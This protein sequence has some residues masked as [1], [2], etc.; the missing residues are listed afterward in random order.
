MAHTVLSRRTMLGLLTTAASCPRVF[1]APLATSRADFLE[2]LSRRAFLYFWERASTATG[3]VLDRAVNSDNAD[4]RNVASCAATGFGLTALCIAAKRG[5]MDRE[6][7]RQRALTTLDHFAN[8]AAHEQGWFYHFVNAHTGERVWNSEISSIDTALLLGGVLTARQFFNDAEITRLAD[9]IYG[10]VDFRWM[11][12]GH[13]TLL[14][15]GWKPESGFLGCRW[16]SYSEH[17]I[18]HLLALGSPS[19]TIPAEAWYAWRRP[20]ISYAGINY[21]GGPTLF[22]HQYSHAWVDFRH[23][24][25]AEGA[26][27]DWFANSVNATL[28]HRA[29]CIDLGMTEFPGC[30][31]ANQWG[32]TSSDS[33]KGYVAW[34]GPPRHPAID[35]SIVPCA[36][37]GSLMFT[38]ELCLDALTTMKQ[39][40][41]DRIWNRYGFCDAFHPL[42]GWTAPDV[43]GIDLGITLLSAE[44]AR[45]GSVWQWFMQNEPIRRALSIAN[46]VDKTGKFA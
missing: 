28:A 31:D 16:D 36:A 23:L 29:F 19:L 22:V 41:G 46:I 2:D 42:N 24:H 40:F 34:G 6:R 39:R 25:E 37:A 14:C 33:A 7:L 38:P 3:L 32:I 4:S 43:L 13:P 30:Y 9:K 11:L 21:L 45:S 27:I 5:W 12:D 10:R 26:G 8:Q 18:L 44:N 1:A 35:G 17:S 20:R 15:H